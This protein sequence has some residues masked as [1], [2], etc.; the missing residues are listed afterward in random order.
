MHLIYKN[1]YVCPFRGYQL[2]YLCILCSSGQQKSIHYGNLT[3]FC[4]VGQQHFARILLTRE[5][6]MI[7]LSSTH[8]YR[9]EKQIQRLSSTR[10]STRERYMNESWVSAY[11]GPEEQHTYTLPYHIHTRY[12][13]MKVTREAVHHVWPQ[14]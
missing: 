4:C 6:E 12:V 3:V 14:D 5:K 1:M 11:N 2:P 7:N 10:N 9:R 13:P 8:R